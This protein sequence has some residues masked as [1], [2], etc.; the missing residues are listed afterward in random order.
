MPTIRI[1]NVRLE[2]WYTVT[3]G[4]SPADPTKGVTPCD[5]TSAFETALATEVDIEFVRH[6]ALANP[7][8]SSDV[9]FK[10]AGDLALQRV[11]ESLN[12][13]RA[14]TVGSGPEAGSKITAPGSVRYIE[15][16]G[17]GH[18]KAAFLTR[19]MNGT[20]GTWKL[21]K[22]PLKNEQGVVETEF[23]GCI[24]IAVDYVVVVED[25]FMKKPPPPPPGP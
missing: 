20:S 9:S 7:Y 18:T 23:D 15:H 1:T 21:A 5:L 17:G 19:S 11:V 22:V 6:R 13:I 2:P 24:A 16:S 8:V 3:K 14:I 4:S 25:V 10:S 12:S